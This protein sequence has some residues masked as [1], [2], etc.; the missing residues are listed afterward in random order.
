MYGHDAAATD[1]SE[2][3]LRKMGL[4]P[5]ILA[6]PPTAGET[7]IEKLKRH[8][9]Q[10]G[11][12]GYACVLLTRNDIGHVKSDASKAQARAR[13]NVILELRMVL[14][15]LGRKRVAI[16]YQES[17]EKPSDIHGLLY[18]PFKYKDRRSE[19]EAVQRT[20]GRGTYAGH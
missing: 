19:G 16:L 8:L 13:Q 10:S 17:V 7:V 4:K 6:N 3:L 1:A 12:V 2:L 18:L 9:R 5:I 20:S 11:D 14:A 15:N